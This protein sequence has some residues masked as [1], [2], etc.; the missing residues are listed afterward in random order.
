MVKCPHIQKEIGSSLVAL[1]VRIQFSHRDL[2][3]F[4]G[5]G[6]EFLKAPRGSAKKKERERD[7]DE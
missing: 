6:T 4:P 5:Q 2:G 3:S 1:T 7:R